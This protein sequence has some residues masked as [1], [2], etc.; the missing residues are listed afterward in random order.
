LEKVKVLFQEALELDSRAR[1][2]FLRDKCPE[3]EI[4]AEVERL[5]AEH[6]RVGGFLSTPAFDDFPVESKA[7]S[8]S[9]AGPT[10]STNSDPG[11]VIGRYHLLERIGEDGM[12][13]VWRAEQRE[14]VRRR[15]ALKL[16]KVGMNTREVMRRFESERQ[17]LALMDHPAIAKVFDAGS[18]SEAAPYFVMEDVAGTTQSD[19]G[20]TLSLEKARAAT[21]IVWVLIKAY[22][23][24]RVA[25][26]ETNAPLLGQPYII[27]MRNVR[28]PL[29]GTVFFTLHRVLTRLL[30]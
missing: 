28:A 7:P 25:A 2:A 6:D 18:T 5:L 15:V 30:N 29:D 20:E 8:A 16:V 23:R 10:A 17:A 22:R 27:F 4:Q 3:A 26:V 14:P 13:E 24:I 1:S 9:S 21:A 19:P 12:G 11:T